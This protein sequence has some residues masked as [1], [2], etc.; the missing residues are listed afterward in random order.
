ME[1]AED[2]A[3]APEMSETSNTLTDWKPKAQSST[4]K[5]QC[6]DLAANVRETDAVVANLTIVDERCAHPS[7][8]SNGTFKDYEK[9]SFS[10]EGGR[11]CI[12]DWLRQLCR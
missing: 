8:L 1:T 5:Q 3:S 2:S 9:N 6:A 10:E 11:I 4:C 7:L 12:D